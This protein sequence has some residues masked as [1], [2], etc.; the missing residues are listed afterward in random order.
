MVLLIMNKEQLNRLEVIGQLQENR[1]GKMTAAE[2]LGVSARQVKLLLRAYW[3]EEAE[4]L[5]SKHRGK[6]SHDQLDRENVQATMTN[7]LR[8]GYGVGS[9]VGHSVIGSNNSGRYIE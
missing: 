8:G 1:I 4:G 7:A 2:I 3:R 9:I 5:L 6:P